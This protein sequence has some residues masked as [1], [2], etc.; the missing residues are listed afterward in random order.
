MALARQPADCGLIIPKNH[1]RDRRNSN[2]TERHGPRRRALLQAM[3]LAP[4][5]G[6]L[7]TLARATVRVFVCVK[8]S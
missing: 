4:W 8:H 7:P 2:P 5:L 1:V 6:A 3:A